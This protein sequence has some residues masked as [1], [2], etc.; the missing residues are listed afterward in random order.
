LPA[1][2]YRLG[3]MYYFGRG[4]LERN[5]KKAFDLFEKASENGDTDAQV[6]L[7]M[8]LAAADGVPLDTGRA[9]HWLS[10]A[11]DGGHAAAP[12]YYQL[13]R[14]SPGGRVTEAQRSAYWDPHSVRTRTGRRAE[15]DAAVTRF[16]KFR[17]ARRWRRWASDSTRWFRPDP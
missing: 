16:E 3:E 11:V 6:N 17:P 10:R 13:L 4:G 15:G 9:L 1:A 2:Q 7:A 12:E 14:A 8:M 5:L